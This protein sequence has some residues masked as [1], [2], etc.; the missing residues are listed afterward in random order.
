MLSSEE[1]KRKKARNLRSQKPLVRN[2][3]L[4]YIQQTLW[5][6]QEEC[7]TVK[8]FTD[9]DNETLINALDGNEDEAYEFK[10]MFADLCAECER[11]QE[12]LRDG[13]WGNITKN[14]DNFFVGIG[15]GEVGGGLL[16]WDSYEQDYYNI[17][18]EDFA[19]QD[20]GKRLM[21]LSKE[22]LINTAGNCFKIFMSFY[23]LEYRYNNLKAAIDVLEAQ[24]TEY[25][26][27]IK[28]IE[29]V[30]EEAGKENFESY[31]K[32]TIQFEKIISCLPAEAWLQ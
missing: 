19:K 22:E 6:I 29:R 10:M 2:I 9:T 17:D 8:W 15:A 27:A 4:D 5:D 1:M 30:Y 3:N 24:N 14:F 25:L 16:G 18:Y 32:H 31:D 26:Q 20:C 7:E 28:E 23:G 13:Y 21:R 12:D 11:M